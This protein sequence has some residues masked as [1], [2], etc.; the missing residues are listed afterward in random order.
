LHARPEPAK[1]G[2]PDAANDELPRTGKE[3]PS[4][5]GPKHG[6]GGDRPNRVF[7]V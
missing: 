4:R 5:L 1:T 3:P 6:N 7:V 2:A